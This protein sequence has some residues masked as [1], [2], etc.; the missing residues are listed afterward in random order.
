MRNISTWTIT[1]H[2]KINSDKTN[3]LLFHPY[4]APTF[5][6]T[7]DDK[8]VYPISSLRYLGIILDDRLSWQPHIKEVV[9]EL[10]RAVGIIHRLKKLMPK[11]TLRSVYFAVFHPHLQYVIGIWG[12][13]HT[14]YL[15]RIRVLQN[16]AIRILSSVGHMTR[17]APLYK[18]L[19]IL[20]VDD[21]CTY[22]L[23]KIVHKTFHHNRP[24]FNKHFTC[25]SSVHSYGTRSA[26]RHNIDTPRFNKSSS[27]RGYDFVGAKIWNSIPLD[28]RNLEPHKSKSRFRN[29]LLQQY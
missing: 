23:A 18:N 25:S 21:L 22:E 20:R 14:S 24:D 29:F 6:I 28:I 2:L 15:D 9:T 3:L 5:H 1:N 16:K 26:T 13:A 12:Q 10:S 19:N 27:Q 8:N 7:I 4:P 11:S 17:L